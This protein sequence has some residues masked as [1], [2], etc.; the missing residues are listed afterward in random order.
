MMRR[1]LFLGVVLVL[2]SGVVALGATFA[3]RAQ[4]E[5][6]PSGHPIPDQGEGESVFTNATPELLAAGPL[7]SAPPRP[8]ALALQRVTIAPGGHIVTP[9]DDPRVVLLYVERGTLTVRY[10]VATEVTRGAALATPVAQGREAIP[11][12]T[13]FTMR[14][15]DS[16]LSPAG[17]GGE[18][19]N[20]GSEDVVLL[21]G[22]IVPVPAGTPVAGTPVS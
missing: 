16:S 12:E 13:E 18:L 19:R 21:V 10:T 15:G 5:T 22:L 3:A 8:A 17:T 9:A 2:L 7:P 14:A 6:F 4:S 20:D 1:L 11:A